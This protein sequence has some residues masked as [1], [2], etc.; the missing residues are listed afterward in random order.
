MFFSIFFIVIHTI[1]MSFNSKKLKFIH[2][3]KLNTTYAITVHSFK[4]ILCI[5]YPF[6]QK[7]TLL[8]LSI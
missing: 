1:P 4:A 6:H 2:N 5:M 8:I 3:T 7:F